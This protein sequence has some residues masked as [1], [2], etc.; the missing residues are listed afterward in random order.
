MCKADSLKRD[1]YI[2]KFPDIKAH[3]YSFVISHQEQKLARDFRRQS[4]QFVSSAPNAGYPM[5]VLLPLQSWTL[6]LSALLANW[7][8]EPD[9]ALAHFSRG[10]DIAP[11]GA[12]RV[13]LRF[14][15]A[16]SF[17]LLGDVPSV[18]G[19]IEQARRDQAGSLKPLQDLY[20]SH[21]ALWT[22]LRSSV[23]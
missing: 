20:K 16:R 12:P 6:G 23:F 4:F 9:I 2:T 11:P 3:I 5:L 1:T 18:A 10:L 19:V 13:R 21:E 8:N 22:R 15:A 14:I 17:A 7:R